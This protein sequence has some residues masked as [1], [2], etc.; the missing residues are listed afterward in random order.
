MLLFRCQALVPP[1]IAN[2]RSIHG[3]MSLKVS[4]P[5]SNSILRYFRLLRNVGDFDTTLELTPDVSLE[6]FVLPGVY[7]GL[8]AP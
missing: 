6:L 7:H 4:F 2:W 3:A 1:G 5:A 8:G